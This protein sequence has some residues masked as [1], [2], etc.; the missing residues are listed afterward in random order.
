MKNEIKRM[1][2]VLGVIAF[3]IAVVVALLIG[4]YLKQIKVYEKFQEKF[5]GAEN[6]LVYIGRPTC[7]YCSLLEP[8]LL[9]M[10]ERYGFDYLYVNIDEVNS[11]IVSKI[12]KDIGLTTVGTP[13]LTVVSNGK[14]VASQN[15]YVD[16]DGLFKFLQT[17]DIISEEAK[18]SL[19]YIGLD[20]YKK[21]LEKDESSIVVV[22]QSTCSYCVKAKLV[23]ND[24]ADKEGTEINYLNV[25]YLTSNEQIAEFQNSLEYLQSDWGTP[26]TLI[27]KDGKLVDHL[28]G[29][30]SEAQYKEFFE[31]NGVL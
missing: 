27:V 28:E 26:V 15:G 8:S 7:G 11:G 12:L 16:Y 23:L 10:K 1:Y 6:T 9:D 4:N 17:N 5:N 24:I 3:V 30:A 20:D 21:I 2:I 22:G 13:Y 31:K 19:N 25:S 29:Y 18:L 14:V